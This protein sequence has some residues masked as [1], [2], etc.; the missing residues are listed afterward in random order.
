MNVEKTTAAP[1]LAEGRRLAALRQYDVL[2]TP[3]EEIFDDLTALAAQLCQT[4]IALISL[5]DENRSWFKSRVGLELTDTSRDLWFCSSAIQQH[6]PFVVSDATGDE[7]FSGN[8]LVTGSPHIRFYAGV[9]LRTSTGE[10]LGTL[11][12]LD[13]VPRTLTS[14]QED[15]LQ[16]L[17]RQVMGQLELRRRSLELAERERLLRAIFDS[18]PECVKLLGPDGSL[19][20]MNRAGLEMIEAD[21]LEQVVGHCMYPLV[22]EEHRHEFRALTE[23]VF[24]GGTGSLEFQVAGLKGSSRW[25]ETHAAPLRDEEGNVTA[26]L[27][28]TRDVTKRKQADADLRASEKNFRTLFEQA[29]EGIFVTDPQGRFLDVNPAGCDITGYSSDELSTMAFIDLL[30]PEEVRRIGPELARLSTGGS[31]ASE[32]QARR[33]DGRLFV[34]DVVGKRL[35]DGRLQAFARDITDRKVTEAALR[36]GEDRFRRAVHAGRVGL[37]DWNLQTN[38]VYYSCEWKHQL[39]FGD[40]EITDDLDEWRRRVH[41]EDLEPALERTRVFLA[42]DVPE[43]EAEFRLRHKDGSYR[44]ILS[45]ASRLVDDTGLTLRVLGSHVDVTERNELYAQFLQAQKM[46]SVGQLAGGIAHDFNNLLTVINGTADLAISSLPALHPLRADLG[47]IR[48]AGDRAAALTRQLLALSRQQILEPEVLNLS[49]VVELMQEMLRRL[50]GE[51]IELVFALSAH[52]GS[53]RADRGQIEQVILNLAV[54]ARDAMPDGGRLT[55]ETEES[56]LGSDDAADHLSGRAG[57]HVMLRVCDTGTGMD[58]TTSK[59]IFEPFFTTKELGKGT[60]LGLSMVYGFVKQSGGNIAVHSTPGEGSRF[61]IYLPRVDDAP[62]E[63]ASAQP[64]AMARHAETVLVVEDERALRDLTARIL[65]SAGY[66]VIH[67]CNGEEALALLGL[68]EGR[69]HLMLTDV[70]MPRMNGRD[71]A[72]RVA[73]LRPDVKVLYTSGYTDDAILR[74]GVL[75]DA[76]RFISK[77]FTA[78]ELKRKVSDVLNS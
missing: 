21:S 35:P 22:A 14:S 42:G 29:T 23:R 57:P 41:P 26:L 33:K 12:V 65:Q 63:P 72:M 32:W 58:E 1:A 6:G 76:S 15:A 28:I 31:V 17:G 49:A 68:H 71:L 27:G 52:L 66:T 46:E 9:P 43:Y 64:I 34:C 60:G 20:M 7:H 39:G 78:A 73:V 48:L 25:L 55:I 13:R 70:V 51:D 77:P 50:I 62:H 40:D 2:D 37:W 53:V 16:M 56:D 75:E 11:C 8:A 4:P 61:T 30:Q 36:D 24:R 3:T 67:A 5:V 47:E 19:R 69:V 44:H 45:R 74:H 10:A 38:K 59:K 18:E 54:N